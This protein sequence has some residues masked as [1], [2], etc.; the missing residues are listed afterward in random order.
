VV[1][2]V[3]NTVAESLLGLLEVTSSELV[4]FTVF[5]TRIFF[6]DNPLDTLASALRKKGWWSEST[7]VSM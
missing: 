4:L 7:S 5:T 6:V 1:E 2:P 3:S